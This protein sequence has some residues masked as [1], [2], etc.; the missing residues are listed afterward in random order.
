MKEETYYCDACGVRVESQSEL[1]RGVDGYP[2]I[3][4]VD[5]SV[6]TYTCKASIRWVHPSPHAIYR[7]VLEKRTVGESEELCSECSKK[8]VFEL[9]RLLG[10]WEKK[11]LSKERV[12][13]KGE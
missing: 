9:A 13:Q 6:G 5:S 12:D 3:I 11:V 10:G 8:L 2:V 7:G 1:N 4:D